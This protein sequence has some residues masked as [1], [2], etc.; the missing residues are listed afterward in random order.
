MYM[1]YWI[2]WNW[3]ETLLQNK[4]K[5]TRMILSLQCVASSTV[6]IWLNKSMNDLVLSLRGI[7]SMY[8]LHWSRG[9]TEAGGQGVSCP[10][11][12]CHGVPDVL[13]SAEK[14]LLS[15]INQV[16]WASWRLCTSWMPVLF[17]WQICFPYGGQTQV[18]F[19]LFPTS[20][21]V[22]IA[23]WPPESSTSVR[24][25]NLLQCSPKGT[26]KE[27]LSWRDWINGIWIITARTVHA[28][29]LGAPADRL[30]VSVCVRERTLSMCSTRSLNQGWAEIH[31]HELYHCRLMV[32]RIKAERV[33]IWNP[34]GPQIFLGLGYLE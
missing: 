11:L 7:E 4:E 32:F 2:S 17:S 6:L 13:F 23:H 10:A 33:F 9:E 26:S 3:R 34:L 1:G 29:E 25:G 30:C 8:S 21:N 24:E 18:F 12:P 19:F 27:Q 28:C 14:A 15:G 5:Q 22:L 31:K 16:C 20:T